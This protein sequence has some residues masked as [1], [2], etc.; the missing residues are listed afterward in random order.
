MKI[1]F[2]DVLGLPYDGST[3]EKRGL[4]GSESSVIY[5]SR[6]LTKLGMDVTVFCDC[7]GSDC[8]PGTYD[9][10]EY[11]PIWMAEYPVE[12]DVLVSLRS[13]RPFT[14]RRFSGIVGS[15]QHR[16]LWMHDTF[17]DGDDLI[18]SL[19]LNGTIHEIFT[20]SDWHTTYVT[21]CDHGKR[22]DPAVLKRHVFQTRNGICARPKGWIDPRIKDPNLFV[23]NSSVS[24]G[25]IP[26]IEKVWP[27]VLERIPEARL[28]VL[29]GYYSM[30]EPDEQQLMWKGLCDSSP[31]GVEFLGVVDQSTVSDVLR[32]ASFLLYPS[33]FPET[34][35][36]STLEALAHCV[37]PITCN[38][39]ALEETA[40]DIASYKVPYPVSPD[41]A[42]PDL[43]EDSAVEAFV[44]MTIRAYE[45]TYLTSQKREYCRAV[46][47]VCTWD[48][49][50]LQWKRHLFQKTGNFL[51]VN[52]YRTAVKLDERVARVFGRR[53]AND[54]PTYSS[55][56]EVSIDVVTCV[57][58]AEPFVQ[59][60]VLS[61]A[62]QD[63]DD[64]R[65]LIVDDASTD[66]TFERLKEV[67]DSLP[68]ELRSKFLLFQNEDRVGAVGNQA[69]LFDMCTADVVMVLDG[70]DH[71]VNDPTIFRRYS[72]MYEDGAQFTYGSCLSLA[73]GIPL[74]AQEYPPEVK[75]DRT[76]RD[77]RFAWNVP[78]THLRTF[79]RDLLDGL[80]RSQWMNDEGTEWLDAGGDTAV[81]YSLIERADPDR[82]VA[83]RDVV[84]CYN[85]L[86]PNCDYKTRSLEQTRTAESVLSKRKKR[87]L[88]AIPTAKYVESATFKSIYDLKVPVGYEVDLQF[89]YGYRVDQ[90]RNLIASRVV[91]GYDYLFAVD[92]DVVFTPDTLERL[93]AHKRDVVC[94]VYRQRVEREFI[95]VYDL[96][97]KRTSM[98]RLDGL[99]EVGACGFGCVLVDARV[100]REVG[101]PQFEYHHALD[102]ADTLSEDVDFCMKARSKGFRVWCDPSI[103]CGHIGE[104]VFTL[105]N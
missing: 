25:L 92:H 52:E 93:L 35:G 15:S 4:G 51:P 37:V 5:I 24:K 17:C 60:C 76:Y 29:G 12:H 38:N 65:M 73:D 23:F 66:G 57:R 86:N 41:W 14:D 94:G 91:E 9:G 45:D 19:V 102:H 101:Y 22:R 21:T 27:K 8:S 1:C 89:F 99:T 67:V 46:D 80:D 39:G 62:Q 36:I 44:D 10:V 72:S 54:P 69:W 16:V 75:R 55:G 83:V 53:F 58:D 31:K 47:D 40:V 56:R 26:L 2:I 3:L 71:L 79:K 63:Y 88:I 32:E 18:E 49:V 61:V 105:S 74:V 30:E 59:D 87:I 85:D 70:D 68:P 96:D 77:H 6:E 34:F 82:V 103:R 42:H 98:D 48:T 7:T 78:Y 84:V 100:F 43:D 33:A 13:V 81:F 95:E 28:K 11:L 64:Y 90:V 20:L 50:A 97:L 104:R